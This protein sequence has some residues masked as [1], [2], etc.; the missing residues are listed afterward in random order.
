MTATEYINNMRKA[1]ALRAYNK[2]N[3]CVFAGRFGADSLYNEDHTKAIEELQQQ[4]PELVRVYCVY[5][6]FTSGRLGGLDIF[7]SN[8]ELT[9]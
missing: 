3:K 4:R 9:F 6:H 2:A 7:L 1:E 5:W 8:K